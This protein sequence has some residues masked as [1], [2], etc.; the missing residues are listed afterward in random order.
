MSAT[1]HDIAALL[2]EARATAPDLSFRIAVIERIAR[3]AEARARRALTLQIVAIAAPTAAIVI[4]APQVL[5]NTMLW[6]AA[7]VILGIAVLTDLA[8][9]SAAPKN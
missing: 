9:N 7:A 2:Q 8:Q 3:R 4:S 5:Q 6:L 1:D